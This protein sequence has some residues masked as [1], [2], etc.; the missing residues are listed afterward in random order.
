[1]AKWELE[2]GCWGIA[3][4]FYYRLIKVSYGEDE[5]VNKR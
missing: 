5:M 4:A 2:Q 1:M 3:L